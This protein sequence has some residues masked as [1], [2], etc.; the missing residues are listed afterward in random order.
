MICRNL[1]VKLAIYCV[2]CR[3]LRVKLAI[4][5]VI[6][7]NLRVFSVNFILHKFCLCKK[8]EVWSSTKHF[9]ESTASTI[10][11]TELFALCQDTAHHLCWSL[12]LVFSLFRVS[13]QPFSRS[14]PPLA[15]YVLSD[16]NLGFVFNRLVRLCIY[17]F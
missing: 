7:H 2:I 15:A 17:F 16:S 9:Q 13:L 4:Y 12:L 8:N 6:C 14:T 5:C 1:R 11:F 3:N 10:T